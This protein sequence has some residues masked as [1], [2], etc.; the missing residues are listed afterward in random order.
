ML[1]KGCRRAVVACAASAIIAHTLV[2]AGLASELELTPAVDSGLP[3]QKPAA[4]VPSVEL[5]EQTFGEQGLSEGSD[6]S[7]QV[8]SLP[9]QDE[10]YS[11]AQADE[12]PAAET[13]DGQGKQKE[14]SAEGGVATAPSQQPEEAEDAGF[15]GSSGGPSRRLNGPL[16]THSVGVS[17]LASETMIP[18][19]DRGP[20]QLNLLGGLT[21]IG[22]PLAAVA[23]L[24]GGSIS[25]RDKDQLETFA[26][27]VATSRE[28][29]YKDLLFVTGGKLHGMDEFDMKQLVS[30]VGL[31]N[32]ANGV[33]A[34]SYLQ[35][36]NKETQ[37]LEGA[38]RTHLQLEKIKAT[39]EREVALHFKTLRQELQADISSPSIKTKVHGI[40][41]DGLFKKYTV[42]LRRLQQT[43]PFRLRR[44]AGLLQGPG[45]LGTAGSLLR[46]ID[47]ANLTTSLNE[48]LGGLGLHHL[49]LTN[50]G[51]L[52]GGLHSR[53]Q[54]LVSPSDFTTLQSALQ[55][56]LPFPQQVAALSAPLRSF[57]QGVST[58]TDGA[59]GA[60]LSKEG[61]QPFLSV[62]MA[63]RL[64]GGLIGGEAVA[65]G[66]VTGWDDL[67]LPP[68]TASGLA[69]IM[70]FERFLGK[71]GGV[72]QEVDADVGTLKR[73]TKRR[74]GAQGLSLL[75]DQMRQ[76]DDL[77]DRLVW[78]SLQAPARR[79]QQRLS[80]SHQPSLTC[81]RSRRSPLNSGSQQPQKRRGTP[82]SSL[83][84][85]GRELEQPR[86]QLSLL[87]SSSN[88]QSSSWSSSSS[89]WN[90][91]SWNSSWGS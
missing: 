9:A 56:I 16:T 40:V 84:V 82:N 61:L 86:S 8:A 60:F 30:K 19:Q 76:I 3:E 13:E 45:L 24:L 62:D 63:K 85:K 90:S 38:K 11:A 33:P 48:G 46:S 50:I 35:L 67:G 21:S 52:G 65:P 32:L 54:P 79:L 14:S 72:A 57:Q 51:G 31:E 17:E 64:L 43:S 10:F 58:S 5:Q 88:L 77:L 15:L 23:N 1:G 25:A 26:R 91:S 80:R 12:Q 87:P 74:I 66:G 55:S 2:H 27:R 36:S 20:L 71:L 53:S 28:R 18:R 70:P 42:N 89:S 75:P 4:S 68:S 41:S 39:Y 83:Q 37:T 69:S 6:P 34:N 7:P 73:E 81:S 22:Q 59:I 47:P 29:V 49:H 78:G 44:L